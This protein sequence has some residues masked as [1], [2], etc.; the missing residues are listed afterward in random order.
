MMIPPKLEKADQIAIVATA[1]KVNSEELVFAQKLLKEW[2]LTPVLGS[3]I[4]LSENQFA[5][6]DQERTKDFQQQLDN[7]DIKAIWC[8]RGGYGTIRMLDSLDFSNFKKSPKW[9]IGYSDITALHAQVHKMK[10]ASLHAEMPTLIGE[11]STTTKS[12]LKNILF[13]EKPTYQWQNNSKIFRNGVGEGALVGGNL[14]VL[15]SL[16]GSPT[17]LNP[18]GK[19]LFLEDLDEYLYHIDRMMQNLK[20]N[21]WFENLAGLVVGGMTEMNDNEIP[22]GQTAEEIIWD[23]VKDYSFPVCFNFPAGHIQDNKALIFGEKVVLKV[24][25]SNN[26]LSFH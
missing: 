20:R 16:C 17:S 22:F 4:G 11:K 13:G 3:S 6:T 5:G 12:S 21:A 24:G 9:I 10:I 19:I 1:R 25:K 8:A 18:A 26:N 23:I 7:P 14:S 2:K 15:Y